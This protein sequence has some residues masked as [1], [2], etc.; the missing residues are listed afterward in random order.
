[1]SLQQ[2]PDCNHDVSSTAYECPNCG[3]TFRVRPGI[4]IG[5]LIVGILLAGLIA[6]IIGALFRFL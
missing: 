5:G 2:C 6:G 1:M 4:G 3:A